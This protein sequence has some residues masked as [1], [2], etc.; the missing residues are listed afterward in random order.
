MNLN[1]ITVFP[2]NQQKFVSA[3]PFFLS[4]QLNQ[5]LEKYINYE[6][7]VLFPRMKLDNVI[8]MF[9]RNIS[10]CYEIVD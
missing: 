7:N 2:L 5:H 8:T 9:V 3:K 6:Q 10:L 1:L 4:M